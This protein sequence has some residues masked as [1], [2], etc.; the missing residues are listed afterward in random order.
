LKPICTVFRILPSRPRTVLA[1]VL[2]FGVGL[3]AGIL[4]W[5]QYHFRQAERAL[6]SGRVEDARRHVGACL[7]VRTGSAA[8]LLLAAT[9]ERAC[10]NIQGAENNLNECMRVQ[11]GPSAATQLEWLLIRAQTGDLREIEAGLWK[12]V[13]DG[14]PEAVRI[15]STL[16]RVYIRTFR[17]RNALR[18]LDKWIEREPDAAQAWYLRGW[19]LE[20]LLQPERG[21]E[22]YTRALELDPD[23]GDCRLRL[24]SVLLVLRKP[25]VALP[26]L[27]R[28]LRERPDDVDLLLNLA[29][30]HYLE[31]NGEQAVAELEAVLARQPDNKGALILRGRMELERGYPEQG[32]AWIRKALALRPGDS[33]ALFQL[34][35]CL[36]AQPGRQREATEARKKHDAVVADWRRIHEL[37]DVTEQPHPNSADLLA[38]GGALLLR[39]GEDDRALEW[40]VRALRESPGH[41]ASHEA[42]AQYYEAKGDAEKAAAHRRA[43][44]QLPGAA[45]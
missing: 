16:A 19:V 9:V 28:L 44:D 35:N 2:L 15:L 12:S 3:T 27:E 30:S 23:L 29:Q 38:E 42:L 6:H 7:R 34:T 8:L 14:D 24:A 20:R 10:G 17:L 1:I 43:L 39:V 26:H 36:F 40:Y 21:A 22:N 41:R 5:Y 37:I 33:E 31:G 11:G 4:G 45:R 13:E 32:E 25:Q 18:S